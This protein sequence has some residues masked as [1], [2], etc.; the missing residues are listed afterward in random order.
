MLF[1][2]ALVPVGSVIYFALIREAWLTPLH[3]GAFRADS[4]LIKSERFVRAIKSV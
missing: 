4:L 1:T 2:A 3:Y